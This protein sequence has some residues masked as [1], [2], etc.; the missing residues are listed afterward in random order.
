[1][2]IGLQLAYKLSLGT[3][4]AIPLDFSPNENCI[5]NTP[6]LK[7]AIAD[8]DFDRDSVPQGEFQLICWVYGSC[9]RCSA[10]RYAILV[11]GWATPLKNM[12][13]DWDDEQPNINGKIKNGNQTTNQNKN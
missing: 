11:G 3:G 6:R 13:V 7:H 9:G 12:K 5:G 2:V 10:S 4:L 8:C 1:M